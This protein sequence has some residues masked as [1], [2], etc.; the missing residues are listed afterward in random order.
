MLVRPGSRQLPRRVEELDGVSLGPL[1]E[2]RLLRDE[3]MST[4]GG[5]LM[6]QILCTLVAAASLVVVVGDLSVT[7]CPKGE[8]GKKNII[9]P[10]LLKGKSLL[11]LLREL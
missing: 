2:H 1:G 11:L 7:L 9:E 4:V 6:E 3:A 10:S 8:R 5:T